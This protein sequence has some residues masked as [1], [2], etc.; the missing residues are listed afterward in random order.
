[1]EAFLPSMSFPFLVLFPLLSWPHHYLILIIRF[2]V[3]YFV[4]Q[5]IKLY[6]E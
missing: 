4:L 2:F 5:L 3:F 1:M 6:K